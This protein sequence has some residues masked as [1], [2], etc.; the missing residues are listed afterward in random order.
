ME[1]IGFNEFG[2]ICIEIDGKILV[3]PD[4]EGD[5]ERWGITD[6]LAAEE[7]RVIPPHAVV[8]PATSSEDVDFERE[9]RIDRGFIF[10]GKLF[11]SRQQDRENIQGAASA[12]SIAIGSGVPADSL[13]WHGG[14][15]D[16]MWIAADNSLIAMDAQTVIAFGLKA[17]QHKMEHIF[18]GFALKNAT[19][20]PVDYED[21]AYWPPVPV[22]T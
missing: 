8:T 15:S 17:L 16:F 21:D 11:Q 9:I 13:R 3:V 5:R 1:V 6:W 20:I 2:D 14:D 12:A 18:A 4:N 10:N 22:E 7:G 19:P